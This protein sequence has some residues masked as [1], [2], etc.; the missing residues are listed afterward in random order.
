MLE[1]LVM[2]SLTFPPFKFSTILCVQSKQTK[3]IIEVYREGSNA[4]KATLARQGLTLENVDNVVESVSD[5]V[6]VIMFSVRTFL[7]W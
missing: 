3:E 2:V 6:Q 1:Q 7:H 5:A 4:F